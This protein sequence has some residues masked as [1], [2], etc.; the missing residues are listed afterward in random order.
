[1]ICQWVR[2]LTVGV[3]EVSA[4]N[5]WCEDSI[6]HAKGQDGGERKQGSKKSGSEIMGDDQEE[7]QTD[8]EEEQVN[9]LFECVCWVGMK[10]RSR[11]GFLVLQ[12]DWSMGGGGG[13]DG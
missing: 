3:D 12:T 9:N 6:N 2:Y 8:G 5:D 1:M 7:K 4:D 10:G 11:V 13:G